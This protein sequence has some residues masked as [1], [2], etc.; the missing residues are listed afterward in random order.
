MRPIHRIRA[1]GN[2]RWLILATLFLARTTM[3]FQFQAVASLSSFVVTD[4]GIDYA[5]LGLLIGLYL[6]PGIVIAYPGGL[7]GQYVGDKR[8]A[9]LG[10][11]LMVA[12]GLATAVTDNFTVLAAGRLV[13]GSGAVL[14]N[15]LLTKMT[16][17]WFIGREIGT[18]LAVLVSSWPIGIG[19]ALVTLPWLAAHASPA[20]AFAATAAA[21][22]AVLLL[23]AFIYRIPP[24]AAPAPAADKSRARL[25]PAEIGLVSLAG[26]VWMLFNVG[27]ILIVSFAPALLT[28]RGLSALEAGLV[29]SLVSWT[30]IVT[31]PIG[32]VLIDR[33]GHASALMIVSFLLLALAM[34]L[35]PA[36]P[37]LALMIFIGA[38]IGLPVGAM[39]VLPAEVLAPQN[40]SP[41]MGVFYTWYYVG[42]ALL[43]PAAGVLRDASGSVGAPLWFAGALQLAALAALVLFRLL[44]RRAKAGAVTA[45]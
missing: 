9:I 11:A 24:A 28:S 15:V 38:I 36:V 7:L 10:M 17:D 5:R 29:I 39:M 35:V 33:I 44:Q 4:L 31:I 41:G 22:V 16:T 43:V 45:A 12:G 13:S 19:L 2:T 34:A 1:D 23:I 20:Y 32:G 8:I 21:A 37:S 40:R 6:L 30:V 18:A 27:Y 25:S 26:I 14:L 42:M 3:G